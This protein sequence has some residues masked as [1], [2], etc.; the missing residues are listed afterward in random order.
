MIKPEEI[1][2]VA[3][4]W[5]QPF[6]ISCM[7]NEPFF[8]K[9]IDR[10]GKVK[11]GDIISRFEVLQ[12]EIENLYVQSKNK[13]GLGYLVKTADKNF[14]RSG[15]HELP[16]AIEFE[17]VEDY[18][19]CT[20]KKK[21]WVRFQE[22]YQLLSRHIPELKAWALANPTL[23]CSAS[24][25]WNSMI[26]IC[27]YFLSN[28][29][30]DLYIRQLPVEVHTKFIEDNSYML[31]SLLDFL[32]PMHI[33]NTTQ[34]KFAERYYLKHDEPLI[35]IRILDKSLAIGNGMMDISIRLSDFEKIEWACKNVLVAE[36]KMNF[37]TLPH[38]TSS[39]AIWSGG[40]FN[41]SYLRNVQWLNTKSIYYWGD[42]DEHGFQIL[43]QIRSYFSQT[44][45]IMMDID[46]FEKFQD[47]AGE[48][49]KNAATTLFNLTNGEAL[50]YQS[51]KKRF[52]GNR[53]EQEKIPQDYV[54]EQMIKQLDI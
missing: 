40:G 33:R 11:S 31:Q 43:H 7:T 1:K 8:P 51:L 44:K 37:L 54:E 35:R 41:V 27:K 4:K 3:L 23:L 2:E 39:I 34:K 9:Q 26:K 49:K 6:L 36:N 14:R 52:T 20:G 12:R 13:T 29:R 42:I 45:S 47:F 17:S 19:H 30:P 48:G 28:P 15:A 5:W 22:S 53:L 21:E 25:D 24:T 38:L 10:I 50:L 46:T 32:I 16:D 18:L